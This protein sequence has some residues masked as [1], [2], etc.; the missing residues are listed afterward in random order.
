MHE[1]QATSQG[2]SAP[3]S[4][5]VLRSRRPG[6]GPQRGNSRSQDLAIFPANVRNFLVANPPASYRSLSGPPGPKAQKSLKIVSRGRSPGVPKS[7]EKVSKKS[8]KSGKSLGSVCSG[9][10]RDF[11]LTFW[12]PVGQD[13][14]QTYARITGNQGFA[15]IFLGPFV[16]L[17]TGK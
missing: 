12:D 8:E 5:L 1:S 9:L 4:R 15:Q 16:A 6:T 14:Y 2:V 3:R 10:F 17:N 11:F 7:L 13:F